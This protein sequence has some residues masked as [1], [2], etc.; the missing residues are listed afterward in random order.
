[1]AQGI[2]RIIGGQWRGRKI[3]VPDVLNLRPTPDRVRETLFNWLAPYIV[4]AS[5]L[6]I[7]AGSG[8]LGFE[9]ASRGAAHV[10][11]MDNSLV[12]TKLLQ[13]EAQLFKANNIEVHLAKAPVELHIPTKPFDIVFLDPPFGANLL[14]PCCTYLEENNMLATH[15]HIYLEARET[16]DEAMLPANWQLLKNKRAGQVAY[17]L[18]RRI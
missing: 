3:K 18:A 15:A 16:I 12:V 17:H 7:F 10:V 1:M 13:E 5:C 9:A 6:D 2:I 14:I 4:G 11:M 8:A